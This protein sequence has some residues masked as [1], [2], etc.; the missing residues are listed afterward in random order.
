[1]GPGLAIAFTVISI[2]LFGD[3]LIES[4]DIRSRMRD[5]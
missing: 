1:M 5:T 2:N 4:L 3:A